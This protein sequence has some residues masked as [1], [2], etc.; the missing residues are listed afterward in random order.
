[1]DET[2]WD[3]CFYREVGRSSPTQQ[4]LVILTLASLELDAW[5]PEVSE[6]LRK[7]TEA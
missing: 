6:A 7:E 3:S 4:Y 2:P 5:T 1:M